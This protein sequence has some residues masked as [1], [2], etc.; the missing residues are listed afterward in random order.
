MKRS[1]SRL[2]STK[3]LIPSQTQCEAIC[4][5][6]AAATAKPALNL[7]QVIDTPHTNRTLGGL[8]REVIQRWEHKVRYTHKFYSFSSG[9]IFSNC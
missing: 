8:L 5:A 4:M 1:V 6:S 2:T 3:Q 9:V 7:K